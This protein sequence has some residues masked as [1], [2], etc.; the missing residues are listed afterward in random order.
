MDEISSDTVVEL[1]ALLLALPSTAL[2]L[3]R[4]Y[5]RWRQRPSRSPHDGQFL[6]CATIP[7]LC[8]D[9]LSDFP[10]ALQ[11]KRPSLSI[12]AALFAL[13]IT[14]PIPRNLEH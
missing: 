1:M 11:K 13:R 10:S 5:R 2:I 9:S 12:P 6:M 14:L 3:A 7:L 4:C 8:C